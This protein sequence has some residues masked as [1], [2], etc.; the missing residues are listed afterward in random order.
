M[1]DDGTISATDDVSSA[2]DT[3]LNDTSSMSTDTNLTD[4]GFGNA[5]GANIPGNT[6]IGG[7]NGLLGG[8]PPSA[9]S[10]QTVNPL[11]STS[12]TQANS[13]PTPGN[14]NG[15]PAASPPTQLAANKSSQGPKPEATTDAG[16]KP[17]QRRSQG[18]R[19]GQRPSQKPG[20]KPPAGGSPPDNRPRSEQPP[21]N[22]DPKM[23]KKPPETNDRIMPPGIP[24]PTPQDTNRYKE[25]RRQLEGRSIGI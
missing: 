7:T 19:P 20:P 3:S 17:G 14:I 10:D 2:P 9:S 11:G 23:E 16:R 12:P 5:N 15:T 24:Q 8:D 6:G 13:N 25:F 22:I 4:A 18:A 21:Y 1:S